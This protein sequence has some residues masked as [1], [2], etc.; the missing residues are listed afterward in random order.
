MIV[1]RPN[2]GKSELFNQLI[3][4]RKSIIHDSPN[5]TRDYMVDI[6]ELWDGTCVEIV[7]TGGLVSD[8]S[9]DNILS[10]VKSMVLSVMKSADVILMVVDA[11]EGEHPE[12][13][14]IFRLVKKSQKPFI[15]VA[16]KC[17]HRKFDNY[18]W[19]FQHLLDFEIIPISAKHRRNLDILEERLKALLMKEKPVDSYEEI[20]DLPKVAIVGRPNSGKSTFLNTIAGFERSLVSPVPLTT[21]DSIDTTIDTEW[22]RIILIDTA[23]IRRKARRGSVVERLSVQ[24]SRGA[25]DRSDVCILLVDATENIRHQD[26]SLAGYVLGKGKGLVVGLNKQDLIDNTKEVIFKAK[27]R[28][29]FARYVPIYSLS[30]LNGRGINNIIKAAI[31]IY[32]ERKK[33]VPTSQL[34]RFLKKELIWLHSIRINNRFLKIYYA[35]QTGVEPPVFVFFSNSKSGIHFSH[36][37]RLEKALREGFNFT[38]TPIRIEFRFHSQKAVARP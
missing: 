27:E 18:I 31:E 24:R 32:S 13:I 36:K 11:K 9:E 19:D 34:N 29:K 35:V 3:E 22:G 28:L 1:G 5:L 8:T 15:I 12:D 37:R 26:L 30:A 14:E 2:V 7:D 4:K 6:W 33:R 21:R 17:D 16:N 10:L 23:G 25:I 20:G 38:G